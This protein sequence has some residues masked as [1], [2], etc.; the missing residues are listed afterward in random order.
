M[1]ARHRVDI[2]RVKQ[3]LAQGL[4][5]KVVALRL[6]ISN[7]VVCQIAKGKYPPAKEAVA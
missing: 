5:Q 6:G 2:D 1:P 7:Q 4:Q 3:L